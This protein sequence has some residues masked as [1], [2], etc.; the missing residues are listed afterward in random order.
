M[1]EDCPYRMACPIASLAAPSKPFAAEGRQ[2]EWSASCLTKVCILRTIVTFGLIPTLSPTFFLSRM[3]V[4]TKFHATY[5]SPNGEGAFVVH[6][7]SGID[8]QAL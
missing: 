3:Y 4:T 5:D 6:K 8:V 7:P 1:Q 2:R